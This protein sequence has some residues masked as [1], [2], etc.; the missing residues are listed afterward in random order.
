MEYIAPNTVVETIEKK[1]QK[2][3]T[4]ENLTIRQQFEVPKIVFVDC[5]AWSMEQKT[6]RKNNKR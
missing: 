5:G 3:D 2:E 1:T 4:K 6:K